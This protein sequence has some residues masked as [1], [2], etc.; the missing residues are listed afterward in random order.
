MRRFMAVLAFALL[1]IV[2]I[3]VPAGATTAVSSESSSTEAW[4]GGGCNDLSGCVWFNF[5]FSNRSVTINGEVFDDKNAGST[6]AVFTFYAGG[7]P[8]G[9]ADTR[10]ANNTTRPFVVSATGPVGGISV[11]KVELVQNST[12]HHTLIGYMVKN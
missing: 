4:M 7:Q 11:V 1:G 6:T 10:T 12:G 5:S 8:Y 2:G 9:A 3:S